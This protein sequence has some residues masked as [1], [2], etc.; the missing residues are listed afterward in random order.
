MRTPFSMFRRTF[1]MLMMATLLAATVSVGAF[2]IPAA[3]IRKA[4]DRP[5]ATAARLDRNMVNLRERNL[6]SDWSIEPGKLRNV[7]WSVDVGNK[8]FGSPVVAHGRVFVATNNANP[9]DAILKGNMAVLM[10]FDERD[11]KFLWQIAHEPPKGPVYC[12]GCTHLL[13]STPTVDGRKLYYATPTCEVICA[14]CID[15]TIHWRQDLGKRMPLPL[16]RCACS[17]L[18]ED[19]LVFIVTGHGDDAENYEPGIPNAPSFVALNKHTGKVVWESSLPGAKIIG[20]QWS[21]PT[22]AVV[23]D[24]PQVIFAGGDGVLYAFTPKTGELL[25]K[26]DCL[27]KRRGLND[28]DIDNTFVGTPVVVGNRLYIG[29]GGQHD[30]KNHSPPPVSHFLCLD[31]SKRGDVSIKSYNANDP[32]NKGSALVWAYGGLIVPPSAK[33]PRAHFGPTMSTAAVHDGLVYISERQGY[34]HGLDAV[35]GKRQWMHDV[36]MGIIGSPYLV[37]GKVYLCS[38]DGDVWIVEAGKTGKLLAT[39]DMDE[40]MWTTPTA[41]NGVLYLLTHSKLHAIG[42]R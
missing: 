14:D 39:I 1:R 17:P 23:N 31:I 33:G 28:R 15:G 10:A 35:T 20:G 13:M 25:W 3:P 16:F 6:P 36:K 2:A 41:A 9:R 32:A 34:L 7:K 40:T 42:K 37:D 30:G 21:N 4:P 19:D 18:V 24:V 27:P 26:C 5:P 22:F 8:T 11:G 12:P 29:M 38:E